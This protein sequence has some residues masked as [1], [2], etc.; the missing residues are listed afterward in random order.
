MAHEIFAQGRI[1]HKLCHEEMVYKIDGLCPVQSGLLHDAALKIPEQ[2]TNHIPAA[3]TADF[4]VALSIDP[5]NRIGG[6]ARGSQ[7]TRVQF[8]IP[9]DPFER[10]ACHFDKRHCMHGHSVRVD[11]APCAIL[12]GWPKRF[13][14]R[15]IHRFRFAGVT[16]FG[17]V[18]AAFS[19]EFAVVDTDGTPGDGGVI[20]GSSFRSAIPHKL[21]A[22]K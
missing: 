22:M 2:A 19:F 17:R 9:N 11:R 1:C 4:N 12:R 5:N 6:N 16:F 15:C 21:D 8:V 18:S 20:F 14:G 3:G 10:F 7:A 13:L